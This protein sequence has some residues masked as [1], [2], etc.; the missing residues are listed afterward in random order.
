VT[1]PLI[2]VGAYRGLSHHTIPP[3]AHTWQSDVET[4]RRIVEAEFYVV[5]RFRSRS[6]FPA[7]APAYNL[8]GRP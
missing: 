3:R 6:G 5:E 8:T 4:T 7:K 1:P 2:T